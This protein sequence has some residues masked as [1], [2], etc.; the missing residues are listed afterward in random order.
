MNSAEEPRSTAVRILTTLCRYSSQ[1]SHSYPVH[2][3]ST[4]FPQ[5]RRRYHI[6]F[7]VWSIGIRLSLVPLGPQ[8]DHIC[9]ELFK[10]VALAHLL[11]VFDHGHGLSVTL[12][13]N[14]G[15]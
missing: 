12:N 9:Y 11:V 15:P 3:I 7:E 10:M 8:A 13:R 1:D 4:S 6:S 2:E 5:T 14:L